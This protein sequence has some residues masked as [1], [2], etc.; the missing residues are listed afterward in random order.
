[1]WET[2]EFAR[3]SDGVEGGHVESMSGSWAP[4]ADGLFPRVWPL[5]LGQARDHEASGLG[6]VETPEFGRLDHKHVCG[7]RPHLE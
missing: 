3:H 1:M 7:S 5:S 4:A 2:L 6:V